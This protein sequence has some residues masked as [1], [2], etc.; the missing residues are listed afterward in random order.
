MKIQSSLQTF[1]GLPR[2]ISRGKFAHP[3][4]TFLILLCLG[5]FGLQ[6]FAADPDISARDLQGIP[7]RHKYLTSIVAGAAH[8]GRQDTARVVDHPV[9]RQGLPLPDHLGGDLDGRGEA[10]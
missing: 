2:S 1:W 6:A 5:L 3:W 9:L 7:K 10:G 8:Q 4:K